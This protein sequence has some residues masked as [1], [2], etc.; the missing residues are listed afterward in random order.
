MGLCCFCRFEP[1]TLSDACRAPGGLLGTQPSQEWS[2]TRVIILLLVDCRCFRVMMQ[3]RCSATAVQV[4]STSL[5]QTCAAFLPHS[6][7]AM[8]PCPG[9]YQTLPSRQQT[10]HLKAFVHAA[11]NECC[12]PEEQDEDDNACQPARCHAV[13]FAASSLHHA[14]GGAARSSKARQ[15][16]ARCMFAPSLHISYWS[17]KSGGAQQ[18]HNYLE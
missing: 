10:N 3:L 8:Q 2:S 1:N 6:N 5:L 7:S 11:G 13:A 4:N 12:R 14:Q 17:G 9:M 18:L 16:G 15:P